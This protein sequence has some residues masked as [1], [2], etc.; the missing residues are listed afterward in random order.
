M[1]NKK[2]LH[3]KKKTYSY[4]L[5][6]QTIELLDHFIDIS[7]YSRSEFISLLIKNRAYQLIQ[8][9]IRGYEVFQR[10]LNKTPFDYTSKEIPHEQAKQTLTENTGSDCNATESRKEESGS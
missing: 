2:S 1:S 10:I 9:Q 4:S 3:N 8:E 7:G 5:D 6:D